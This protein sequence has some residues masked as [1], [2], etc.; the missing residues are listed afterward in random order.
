MV[1]TITIETQKKSKPTIATDVPSFTLAS[2]Q[3]NRVKNTALMRRRQTSQIALDDTGDDEQED[4][5]SEGHFLLSMS[6]FHKV[7][8][9]FP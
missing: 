7:C 8:T 6:K 3:L 2:A 4:E 5:S 1:Q 9:I